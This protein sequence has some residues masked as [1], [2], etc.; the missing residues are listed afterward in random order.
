ME[1]ESGDTKAKNKVNTKNSR[2]DPSSQPTNHR[3]E[4]SCSVAVPLPLFF[5]LEFILPSHRTF[6]TIPPRLRKRPLFA[7]SDLRLPRFLPGM[8]SN[9]PGNEGLCLKQPNARFVQ[10]IACNGSERWREREDVERDYDLR[11]INVEGIV[12]ERKSCFC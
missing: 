5:D 2:F 11:R 12:V 6:H 3:K 9:R 4:K 10:R 1:A 7:H 8:A